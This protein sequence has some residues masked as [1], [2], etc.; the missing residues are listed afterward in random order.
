MTVFSI[1][2]LA[3]VIRCIMSPKREQKWTVLCQAINSKRCGEHLPNALEADDSASAAVWW[4][5]W[6]WRDDIEDAAV[7]CLP[8][9]PPAAAVAASPH[10]HTYTPG[11]CF[12]PVK[13]AASN[14][15]Q[16]HLASERSAFI[17]STP[18]A[19][20]AGYTRWRPNKAA[21]QPHDNVLFQEITSLAMNDSPTT[22]GGRR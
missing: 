9:A 5:Q 19:K 7:S 4:W 12:L 6:S 18:V 14:C 16:R 11:L 10:T 1:E 3:L 22:E 17:I 21:F 15:H 2:S 13:L 8:P 20:A